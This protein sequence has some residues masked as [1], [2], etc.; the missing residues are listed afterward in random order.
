MKLIF[1]LYIGSD[2]DS[3]NSDNYE[4]TVNYE[5]D[6]NYEFNDNESIYNKSEI[7]IPSKLVNND[8]MNSNYDNNSSINLIAENLRVGEIRY[9]ALPI[10][11]L[12]ISEQSVKQ[13]IFAYDE[14]QNAT[15]TEVNMNTDLYQEENMALNNQKSIE[16]QTYI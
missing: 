1:Y 8:N 11:Y 10:E 13:C 16:M 4:P 5:S 6:D 12:P 9:S 14:I 2:S 15:H 7:E 3:T